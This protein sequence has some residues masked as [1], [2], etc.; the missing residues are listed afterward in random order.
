[1]AA[2]GARIRLLSPGLL[3]VAVLLVAPLLLVADESLR[4]YVPGHIGSLAGAP[5]T[6]ANYSELLSSA[7]ADFFLDTFRLSFITSIIAIALGLPIAYLIA[8]EVSPGVRRTWIIFLVSLLFLSVLV[9]TYALGLAA[10]PPGYGR[11]ISGLLG[12]G[13]NSRMYAEITVIAGLLH[14]VLPMAILALLAPVQT[15]NPR[16]VDAAETLGAPRWWAHM[17]ITLPLSSRALMAAF[18]VAFTFCISAFV[19]PMVLGKGRV[20]FVANLIYTRFGEVGNF[21][22]GAALA[23]SLL[24]ASMIFIYGIGFASSK[25]WER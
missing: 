9:R 15:L 23:V 17:S 11:T 21:P 5:L 7:Y 3:I 14:C 25:L 18:L 24:C 19:I 13:L 8:H 22:S 4:A 12:I 20:M 16:L 10:G 2:A 6:L 1:M